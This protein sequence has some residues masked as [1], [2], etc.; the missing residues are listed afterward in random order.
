MILGLLKSIDE[1]ISDECPC[2]IEIHEYGL[3]NSNLG[4]Q[5]SP[6]ILYIVL[7]CNSRWNNLK[8]VKD[9]PPNPTY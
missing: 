5:Y 3:L 8:S 9:R 2:K 7:I 6:S 1:S 4:L